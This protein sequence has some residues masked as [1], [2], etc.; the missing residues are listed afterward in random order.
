MNKNINR[1]LWAARY[2]ITGVGFAAAVAVVWQS[3]QA[4]HSGT[5]GVVRSSLWAASAHIACGESS[6]PADY[7]S[8]DMDFSGGSTTSVGNAI[9]VSGVTNPAPLAVYQSMR[10]GNFTYTIGGFPADVNN[11]VRLHFADTVNSQAGQ[12]IFNV[13]LNGT[14][15]LPSF[16]IIAAAGAPNTAI[17]EQFTVPPNASGQYVIQFTSLTGLSAVSGVEVISGPCATGW[18]SD[19]FGNAMAGCG[20]AVPW[21]NRADLCAPGYQVATANEWVTWRSGMMPGQDYWTDDN[22]NFSGSGSSS[23]GAIFPPAGSACNQDQ[24]MRVCS[25]TGADFSGNVCNWA[26]C[27]LSGT[28]PNQFFGGCDGNATAGT[29]C[30][31][32]GLWDLEWTTVGSIIG[33]SGLAVGVSGFLGTD[34]LDAWSFTSGNLMRNSKTGSSA[35]GTTWSGWGNSQA[36]TLPSGHYFSGTPAAAYRGNNITD[37]VVTDSTGLMWINSWTNSNT[38]AFG[39]ATWSGWSPAS[40]AWQGT[41]NGDPAVTTVPS[42]NRTDVW[43]N[44]NGVLWRLNRTGST[45]AGWFDLGAPAGKRLTGGVGAVVRYGTS[46]N[47]D[48]I[49][50]MT[51]GTVWRAIWNE[52]A[53]TVSWDQLPIVNSSETHPA[54]SSPTSDRV[55][56]WLRGTNTGINHWSW[57]DSPWAW[58]A[59]STGVPGGPSLE[60]F[61]GP[62][63]IY[64]SPVTGTDILMQG[65][66]I[67][68]AYRNLSDVVPSMFVVPQS[69]KNLSSNSS[70]MSTFPPNPSGTQQMQNVPP[71]GQT[72][73]YP[74]TFYNPPPAV[75]PW[76][77]VSL[78]VPPG[79]AK[80]TGGAYFLHGSTSQQN[81]GDRLMQVSWACIT[82]TPAATWCSVS[83]DITLLSPIATMGISDNDSQM[84]RLG[85]GTLVM[86]SL[87][88]QPAPQGATGCAAF[89]DA[90]GRVN[91]STNCGQ[92]WTTQILDPCKMGL[93]SDGTANGSPEGFD[94]P[95]MY[96]DPWKVGRVYLTTNPNVLLK[97]ENI[98][99]SPPTWTQ[100]GNFQSRPV[101]MTSTS[102]GKLYTVDC[103]AGPVDSSGLQTGGNVEVHVFDPVANSFSAAHVL[104]QDCN[105]FHT[106]TNANVPTLSISR[107]GSV[108]G[109]DYLRITYPGITSP[110]SSGQMF[111]NLLSFEAPSFSV[112]GK[113]QIFASS[114]T[115]SIFGS[116]AIEPDQLEVL[117]DN[118]SNDGLIYWYESTTTPQLTADPTY[119]GISPSGANYGW[120]FGAW[121]VKALGVYGQIETT[122][123]QSLAQPLGATWP[124]WA[125]GLGPSGDYQKGAFFFDGRV[126]RFIPQWI[127]FDSSQTRTMHTAIVTFGTQAF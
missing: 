123:A 15:V 94:R 81:I 33:T 85:D 113:K 82:N 55:D 95:E 65:P 63:A 127:Q 9:N 40:P 109:D 4:P 125:D 23:C 72:E 77:W 56:V 106:P 50:D 29:L 96:A 93:T 62:A 124:A 118:T 104:A 38:S 30:I 122:P 25:G 18:I 27:G 34:R 59:D 44:G 41:A 108:N 7:W 46:T 114:P 98:E 35:T 78:A 43:I 103:T 75:Q 20:G 37:I 76:E 121:T 2:G 58:A 102:S 48:I 116:S 86:L 105:W 1:V 13:T 3:C 39:S 10:N 52:S 61:S 89:R 120:S 99:A 71:F 32:R 11:T 83:N 51:D 79:F 69:G 101:N 6:S 17:V 67:T 119:G 111:L 91:T 115:G 66:S 47:I 117:T 64:R 92:T 8:A 80:C 36:G 26:N 16:D 19:V 100:L 42:Q 110:T 126:F 68:L 60:A 90:V 88:N 53:G 28:S 12:R 45:W 31:K 97:T 49:A 14:V 24:P 57:T 112:T 21:L 5:I 84:V 87:G 54:I 74:V 70:G 107:V 73:T 22:L